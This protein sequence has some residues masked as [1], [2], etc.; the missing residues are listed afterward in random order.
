MAGISRS[1]ARPDAYE[2]SAD[3][4]KPSTTGNGCTPHST[5]DRRRNSRQTYRRYVDLHAIAELTLKQ[6]VPEL[7]CLITGV[8]SRQRSPSPHCAAIRLGN[9]AAVTVFS[10]IKCH[11]MDLVAP[12]ALAK[13]RVIP[14]PVAGILCRRNSPELASKKRSCIH[15]LQ[16]EHIEEQPALFLET[17]FCD[18][19]VKSF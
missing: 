15:N 10:R 14:Y 9:I 1:I 3:S 18:E 7:P 13:L 16:L 5:I 12:A 19:R 17:R 8:H 2:Q 11:R 4:S 6:P